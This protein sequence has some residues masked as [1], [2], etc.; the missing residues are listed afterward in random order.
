MASEGDA[1][2]TEGAA[3]ISTYGGTRRPTRLNNRYGNVFS[4]TP[5]DFVGDT[6]KIGDILVLRSEM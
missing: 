4:S 2:N 1:T 5:K 3:Q 6:P